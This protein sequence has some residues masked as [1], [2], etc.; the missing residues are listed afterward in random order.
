MSTPETKRPA[1]RPLRVVHVSKVKGIAGSE[2]HLLRLLPGLSAHGVGVRMIVLEDPRYPAGSFY[3]ALQAAGVA[4]ET[5]RLAGHV[6]V[7]LAGRLVRRLRELAPDI[8][9]SHLVHADWYGLWAAARAGVPHA[10]S[11]RHNDDRFRWTRAVRWANRWAMRRADRVIAVSHALAR[12]VAEVEGV[13]PSRIVAVHYGLEAQPLLPDGR[14]AARARLGIAQDV[15]LVGVVA[16]LVP[17]KGVE[18]LIDAF[19]AV[20]ARH[21]T[22]QLVVVGDGPL[23]RQL[24]TRAARLGAGS[25]VRFTGWLDDAMTVM[26][27]CDV[28][29][30]PS[31]WEGFGLTALEAMACARPVVATNVDALPEIVVHELTGLLVTPGDAAAL[32]WAIASLLDD[33]GRANALGLAGFARLR[34]HFRV[35]KMVQATLDV[36]EAVAPI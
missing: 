32:A 20:R 36:Y 13:D 28:V 10:V 33:D 3:R 26:P 30:V 18:V 12:F 9:H 23:R 14:A 7:G 8:V 6:D 11:S 15:P 34:E 35:E 4:V 17:Q 22:A 25:T 31:R 1:R 29:V 27:A 19:P 5:E 16:R 21:P 2:G 24:E